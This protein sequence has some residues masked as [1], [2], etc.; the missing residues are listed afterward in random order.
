MQIFGSSSGSDFLLRAMPG[1]PAVA[2]AGRGSTGP[3]VC[4]FLVVAA[5]TTRL[6]VLDS[7]RAR[8]GGA[9]Q[10]PISPGV[11]IAVAARDSGRCR[12]CGS[13]EALH[14]DHVITWSKG[15]SNNRANI[16][17]L[18]R[19]LQPEQRRKRHSR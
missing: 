12:Q 13:S 16:Q 2:S 8:P 1:W 15:G 7:G 10:H 9:A 5:R 4:S 11:K 17:L 19:T 18:L 3:G 14:C 6:A